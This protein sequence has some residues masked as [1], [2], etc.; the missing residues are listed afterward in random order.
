MPLRVRLTPMAEEDLTYLKRHHRNVRQTV[1]N[2]VVPA[3]ADDPGSGEEL[4]GDLAGIRAVHFWRDRYRLAYAIERPAASD[5]DQIVVLAVGLKAG[6]YDT[7]TER[8]R[9]VGRDEEV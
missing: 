4:E 6:F 2:E 7:L 5:E 1:R 3:L 9:Y 8:V